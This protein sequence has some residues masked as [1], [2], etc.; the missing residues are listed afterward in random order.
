MAEIEF[1]PPKP[2]SPFRRAPPPKVLA[3]YSKR[4]LLSKANYVGLCGEEG[5]YVI[6]LYNE[7]FWRQMNVFFHVVLLI[8]LDL[9]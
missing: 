6:V 4:D 3:G 9:M 8:N 7:L 1:T 2:K 5:K